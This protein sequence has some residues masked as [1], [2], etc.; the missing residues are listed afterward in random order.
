MCDREKGQVPPPWQSDLFML[1]KITSRRK[2]M[3]KKNTRPLP[4]LIRTSLP[5]ELVEHI[6]LRLVSMLSI[7]HAEVN[8]SDEKS[9]SRCSTN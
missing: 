6:N 4:P 9:Y 2:K 3:V 5:D 1:F 8:I 7:F